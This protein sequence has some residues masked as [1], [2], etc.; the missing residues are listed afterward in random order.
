LKISI[1]ESEDSH[2]VRIRWAA[3]SW[4]PCAKRGVTLGK[5][6]LA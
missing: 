2:T 4:P 3:E 6:I 1:F 5:N